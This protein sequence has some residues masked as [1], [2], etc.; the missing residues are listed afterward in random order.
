M[1][2]G[3]AA[4]VSVVAL[5]CAPQTRA[6]SGELAY[7]TP[8]GGRPCSAE[9][10]R[11]AYRAQPRDPV[12]R[13]D[14]AVLAARENDYALASVLLES[15]RTQDGALR[16]RVDGDRA[17]VAQLRAR[18]A[19]VQG[20]GTI[21]PFSEQAA[22]LR[23]EWANRASRQTLEV[24]FNEIAVREIATIALTSARIEAQADAM[25]SFQPSAFSKWVFAAGVRGVYV[26]QVGDRPPA[27]TS[28]T[29][30]PGLLW[31][32]IAFA[33]GE[34][35]TS[36]V[37]ATSAGWY[38]AD[39][40]AYFFGLRHEATVAIAWPGWPLGMASFV[41]LL[42]DNVIGDSF[43]QSYVGGGGGLR[44]GLARHD[45]VRVTIAF[46]AT[47]RVDEPRGLV[48]EVVWRF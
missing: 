1:R 40:D 38:T 41:T 32:M 36:L 9:G 43:Q 16:R 26:L 45:R 5:G 30:H 12:A 3:I 33:F 28:P 24:R 18:R 29:D 20:L 11:R 19:I 39:S 8:C 42:V 31:P 48:G 35:G 23:I 47:E 4:V 22:R 15:V 21:D 46:V 13:H 37:M 27:W 10:V 44:F 7:V 25:L 14:R 6:I 17:T 34:R 2:W